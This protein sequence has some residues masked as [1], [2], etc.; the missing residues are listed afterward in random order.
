MT[1]IASDKTYIIS[2]CPGRSGPNLEMWDL[3]D[4][5]RMIQQEESWSMVYGSF[6]STPGS[7]LPQSR[8]D[9]HASGDPSPQLCHIPAH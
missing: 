4:F 1:H 9:T 5:N 2:Y 6:L 3:A 7:I 8:H